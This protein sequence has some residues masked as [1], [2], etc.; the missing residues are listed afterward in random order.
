MFKICSKII[1]VL[2]IF[3]FTAACSSTTSTHPLSIHNQA[4]QKNPVIAGEDKYIIR[5]LD[6]TEQKVYGNAL[7]IGADDVSAYSYEM[8]EWKRY[9]KSDIDD[10]FLEKNDQQKANKNTALLTGAA[11]LTAF[12]AATAGGYFLEKEL[13]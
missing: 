11:V 13:R 7:Q 10:I 12:I 9:S 5:F 2:I 6:G 8:R 3:S 4:G 1:A